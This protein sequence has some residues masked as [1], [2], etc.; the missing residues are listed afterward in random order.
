MSG[1]TLATSGDAAWSMIAVSTMGAV[2]PMSAVGVV[3]TM[4]TM[5][6]I[7]TVDAVGALST[8]GGSV[9]VVVHAVIVGRIRVG[10]RVAATGEETHG[11]RNEAALPF[12]KVKNCLVLWM[13]A[14]VEGCGRSREQ[15][16][17]G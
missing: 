10:D 7:S 5:G 12:I 6:T 11:V 8:M 9:V 13:T 3:S 4:S 15:E 2:S 14:Q 16:M 17:T 1:A